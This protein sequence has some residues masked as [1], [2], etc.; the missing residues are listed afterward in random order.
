MIVLCITETVLS[1]WLVADEDRVSHMLSHV[2]WKKR[3]IRKKYVHDSFVITET[4]LSPWLV[5]DEDRVSHMLSH[6]LCITFIKS[7]SYFSFV[8]IKEYNLQCTSMLRYFH[9]LENMPPTQTYIYIYI[10]THTHTCIVDKKIKNKTFCDIW[11]ENINLH[12]CGNDI[13]F[14]TKSLT[15]YYVYKSVKLRLIVAQLA[16]AVEYTDCTSAEG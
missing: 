12:I 2:W 4:V 5:A 1:P 3:K 13:H 16:G 8:L 7:K 10:Y 6:V 15:F 14:R 11:S 9:C